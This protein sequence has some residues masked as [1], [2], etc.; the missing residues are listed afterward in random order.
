V[1]GGRGAGFLHIWAALLAAG[2]SFSALLCYAS[3]FASAARRVRRTGAAI[4]GWG[5]ADDICWSDGVCVR[6]EDIFPTGTLSLSGMKSYE[7]VSPE[8]A[9][10]YTGSIIIASGSG[11]AKLFS[12]VLRRRG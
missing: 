7:G 9:I 10:R 3:P 12:G 2:A 4:A 6:D 11:L 8:K 5:G 1:G